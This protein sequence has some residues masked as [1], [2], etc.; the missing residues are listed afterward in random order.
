MRTRQN[1]ASIGTKLASSGT[2]K[3][4]ENSHLNVSLNGQ[5]CGEALAARFTD[6]AAPDN[7]V[8]AQNPWVVLLSIRMGDAM[9][10]CSGTIITQ[11]H[12]VTNAQC[13]TREG[14]TPRSVTVFYSSSEKYE[15]YRV[16]GTHI[17]IHPDFSETTLSS[18]IAL[19]MVESHFIQSMY[20]QPVCIPVKQFNIVG[21]YI[22]VA[23]WGQEDG[24][25]RPQKTMYT[26]VVKVSPENEC[27]VQYKK[28]GFNGTG[29]LCAKRV[30]QNYCEGDTGGPAVT[31]GQNGRFYLVGLLS[32]K[33]SCD[34]QGEHIY[35]SIFT[36]VAVFAP[37]IARSVAAPLVN[38]TILVE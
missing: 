4:K 37:W 2:R 28:F 1:C 13:M 15:G 24:S 10:T 30:D 31:A 18:D 34:M 22:I 21:R 38:Y 36:K 3:T 9:A 35:P 19:I 8:V 5:D 27:W 14:V 23:G 7:V 25:R 26:T 12:V 33:T 11:M 20:A 16:R 29:M 32:Y 6:F 17:L